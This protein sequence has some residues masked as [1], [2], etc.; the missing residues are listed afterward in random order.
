MISFT[1]ILKPIQK[2]L[3]DK[4]RMLDK[5]KH[6]IPI[7]EPATDG[8]GSGETEENYMYT[9]SVMLRMVSMLTKDN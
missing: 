8:E 6:A 2:T 7:N 3:R 5:S 1:P 4:M 9:R